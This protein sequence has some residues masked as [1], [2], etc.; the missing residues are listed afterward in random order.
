[1]TAQTRTWHTAFVVE[2][3]R[4]IAAQP[5]QVGISALSMLFTAIFFAAPLRAVAWLPAWLI[6][7]VAGA[8][9]LGVEYAF[10]KGISDRAF[11]EAHGGRG[12][13]GDVLVYTTGGLLIVAGTTVL[14]T[15]AYKLPDLVRPAPALAALLA[16]LHIVPLALIG[17]C[18]AQLHAAAE[19][20]TIREQRETART[21]E[22]RKREIDL[23]VYEAEQK[24]LARQRVRANTS[25]PTL[26]A[27]GT[28]AA[29]PTNTS[30]EHLIEQIARTLSEHPKANR[31]ELARSLG[32]GRTTLYGLISEAQARG[33]LPRD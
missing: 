14:L 25:E 1:M 27:P 13:W 8:A 31:A 32:I 9:A 21:F 22:D 10:L 26:S 11:V 19:R 17:V 24:A 29:R 4:L 7:G 3:A 20:V 28:G 6:F 2:P 15:Y 30:R 16:L 5:A 18:S 12:V 33:L 23:E